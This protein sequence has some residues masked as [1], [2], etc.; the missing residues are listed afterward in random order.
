MPVSYPNE[1]NEYRLARDILLK[2]EVA[3]RG[4]IERVA[5][6]R[7]EL[8]DGGLIKENYKFGDIFVDV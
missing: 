5:G 7:R 4:R 8:P 1:S 6:L 2:E 3:L